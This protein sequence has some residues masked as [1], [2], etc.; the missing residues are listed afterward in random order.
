MGTSFIHLKGSGNGYGTILRPTDGTKFDRVKEI[1]FG[2]PQKLG[3]NKT[4]FDTM[5]KNLSRPVRGKPIVFKN[6]NWSPRTWK[7]S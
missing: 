5:N 3:H 7:I 6:K 2:K 4:D 1:N